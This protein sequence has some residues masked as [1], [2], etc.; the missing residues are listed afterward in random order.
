MDCFLNPILSV[1]CLPCKAYT[2]N[3]ISERHFVITDFSLW[4]FTKAHLIADERHNLAKV[5]S[6]IG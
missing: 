6:T 1:D 3:G 2:N 4:K 5:L